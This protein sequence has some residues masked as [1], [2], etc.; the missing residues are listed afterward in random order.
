MTNKEMT[1]SPKIRRHL[2][3]VFQYLGYYLLGIIFCVLTTP[4]ELGLGGI[5]LWYWYPLFAVVGFFLF[6]FYLT[7][8]YVAS[9]SDLDYWLPFLFGLLPVALQLA[10]YFEEKYLPASR[11]LWIGFP[12]GFVGTI[13]LFYTAAASV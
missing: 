8:L 4:V 9:G 11:P 2:K 3:S 6:Y 5:Q 10:T 13:G 7:Q 12:V 1:V